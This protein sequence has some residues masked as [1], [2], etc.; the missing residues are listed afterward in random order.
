MDYIYDIGEISYYYG[1]C[2]Y[3]TSK[4]T[5]ADFFFYNSG[6]IKPT[7]TAIERITGSQIK[8]PYLDNVY[9]FVYTDKAAIEILDLD[10]WFDYEEDYNFETYVYIEKILNEFINKVSNNECFKLIHKE[11]LMYVCPALYFN[12]N[13]SIDKYFAIFHDTYDGYKITNIIKLFCKRFVTNMSPDFYSSSVWISYIEYVRTASSVKF[14]DRKYH[15]HGGRRDKCGDAEVY[16]AWTDMWISF[17]WYQHFTIP[18]VERMLNQ[19]LKDL[20]ASRFFI[21]GKRINYEFNEHSINPLKQK[22]LELIE[23][24]DAIECKFKNG[25]IV[26]LQYC[27]QL[28]ALYISFIKSYQHAMG[29]ILFSKF[30]KDCMYHD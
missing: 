8:F 27:E 7:L 9:L 13:C 20:Q 10:Y 2:G 18:E 14:D 26:Y 28:L 19:T 24:R 30:I 5:G 12:A 17:H 29:D 11:A 1:S 23:Q 15:F 16:K 4:T 21:D 6:F 25:K 3:I 22:C